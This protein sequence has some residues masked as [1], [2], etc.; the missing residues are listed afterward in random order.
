MGVGGSVISA[1]CVNWAGMRRLCNRRVP[2]EKGGAR[3]GERE[4]GGSCDPR[5]GWG[6]GWGLLLKPGALRV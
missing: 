3:E 6:R 1:E 5:P 4:G 2:G